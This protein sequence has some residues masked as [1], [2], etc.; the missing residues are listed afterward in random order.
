MSFTCAT[1]GLGFDDKNV[2]GSHT[3]VDV[4]TMCPSIV[5]KYMV[6]L[7]HTTSLLLLS[8]TLL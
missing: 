6:D 4:C 1:F 5:H 8:R 7:H 2:Y 3:N